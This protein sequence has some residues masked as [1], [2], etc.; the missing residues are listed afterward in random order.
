MDK[1]KGF[2]DFYPEEMRQRRRIFNVCRE[3][4]R[5]FGYEEISFPSIEPLEL[6]RVKSG[7]QILDQTYSFRDKGARELTLIPEATPSVSRM[8]AER[9]DLPRPVRW[10]SLE[11]YWRYEEPQAG[12]TREFYQYN[13][14]LF[15]PYSE[16]ADAEI[17]GLAGSILDNLG[18]GGK[19][20]FHVSHRKL[21]ENILLK[22]GAPRP[23]DVL[24]VIDRFHKIPES[25]SVEK[26]EQAGIRSDGLD[27]LVR[28][29]KARVNLE[30]VDSFLGNAGLDI[31]GLPE[32]EWLK[33]VGMLLKPYSVKNV[34]FDA[35]IVR[36][37][38]YYT[39]TVF[40]AFDLHEENRAILGG[41]RYDNLVSVIS[42]TSIPA[43][44]FGMGDVVLELVMKA[45]GVWTATEGELIAAV[46]FASEDCVTYAL[47]LASQLRKHGI[48]ALISPESRSL[49]SQMK[50]ASR[51]GARFALIVG[52][53]EKERGTVTV[54]RMSD[55]SQKT[56]TIGEAITVL[57]G[58]LNHSG[59]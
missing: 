53:K 39:G 17:I 5:L 34:I 47:D 22:L 25:A 26:L 42:G 23:A 29:L 6:F 57:T 30:T 49:S 20:E 37:F 58:E 55:G 11:K 33:M 46:C 56:V 48:P 40:E 2:R 12:R 14:D 45:S 4:S 36:G 16:L 13:G 15:G 38:A 51:H 19:Y 28:M 52:E 32:V 10:F 35:S 9:K 31:A 1:L 41:G 59:E 21:M 8:L 3:V 27:T 50:D 43:I 54:K 44:G 7:D 24:P 18:L